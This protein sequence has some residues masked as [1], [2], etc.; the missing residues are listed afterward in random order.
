M[1]RAVIII[2]FFLTALDAYVFKGVQPF[3][4]NAGRL[5]WLFIIGYWA[6]SLSVSVATVLFMMKL[7]DIRTEPDMLGLIGSSIFFILFIP[8]LVFAGF[9]LIDDVF[10]GASWLY[11]KVSSDGT[12]FS[13][14]RFITKLG[15]GAGGVLIGALT[16]GVAKGRFA[17]KVFQH[18][19]KSSRIPSSFDGF[20]IVQLSDA[21]LGSF[22]RQ[23]HELDRLVDIVNGLEPDIIVF[24]GDMVNNHASE[25]EGWEDVFGGLKAKMGKYSIFG[26]H[27]Y[28]HYGPYDETQRED[29]IA[30]LKEVHRKMGFQLMEDEHVHL[31][32]DSERIALLGVHN[33]GKG[34]GE[35]GDLEKAYEGLNDDGFKVLL[36]H[37]PTHFEEQVLGKKSID[38]TLSGHTHGM[39]M[40]IEI[41]ALGLKWSPVSLRYKRWAGLYEEAGQFLN[42]NRGMGVIAYPGR[43]GMPPEITCIDLRSE[44]TA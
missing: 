10:N 23:Y 42:V 18:D 40:G 1:T 35:I 37:D 14:R 33:W 7:R 8:K 15:L 6:I 41:P 16:Y 17:F 43:V 28:A 22:V 27:D 38:L 24:T 9:H 11:S 29:S 13:R 19:L 20:R 39:Q 26:N 21:H 5:R 3:F 32:R 31:E 36:S 4:Q 34:F 12:D 2:R 44:Q 30:R 25:A